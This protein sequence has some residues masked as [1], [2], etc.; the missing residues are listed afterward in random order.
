[1]PPLTGPAS[2]TVRIDLSGKVALVTGGG[3]GMGRASARRFAAC[4]AAVVVADIDRVTGEE[5]VESIRSAGGTATFVE[6]DVGESDGVRD[7]VAATV[8]AYGGLDYAHNNAGIIEDQEPVTRFPEQLWDRIIR[9]NLT[10][11]FLCLKYEIPAM[12]ERGGGAI[13]NVASETTYKGNAG[14]VAYTASKHGVVGLTQVT[15]LRY[16]RRG[17][18]INVIAPGNIETGIVERARRYMSP[19]QVRYMETV[20]PIGRLGRPEEVAELVVWLCSDAASLINATRV[21]V[22]SG[23]HVS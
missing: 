14:D 16:A 9:T 4:G 15:G 11:T 10:G 8:A 2:G 18:R 5:T 17:I 13:V 7:M 23:W 1:M 19:E 12:L 20:M 21:A 22:D 3:Y 6:V